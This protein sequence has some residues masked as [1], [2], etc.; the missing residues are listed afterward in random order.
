M[1]LAVPVV[2][3]PP[4]TVPVLV[5]DV[6]PVAAVVESAPLVGLPS[7][8]ARSGKSRGR[9]ARSVHV[10]LGRASQGATVKAA[11]QNSSDHSSI[12]A[13]ARLSGDTSSYLRTDNF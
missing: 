1:A 3:T 9:I 5:L 4:T 7:E 13:W 6:G 10:V 12:P 8:G 2:V 11:G